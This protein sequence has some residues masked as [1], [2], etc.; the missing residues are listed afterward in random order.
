[1]I[2]KDEKGAEL[3]KERNTAVDLELKLNW[4][5]DKGLGANCTKFW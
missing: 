4:K 2:A 1:M 3:R 5:G